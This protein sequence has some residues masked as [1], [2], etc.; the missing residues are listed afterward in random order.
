LSVWLAVEE[1]N[2]VRRTVRDNLLSIPDRLDAIIAAETD[3]RKVHQ[4]LSDELNR[5]L[6]ELTKPII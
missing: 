2:F 3:R 6:E 1:K 5:V 4:I